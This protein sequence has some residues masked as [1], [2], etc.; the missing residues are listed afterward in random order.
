MARLQRSAG[1]VPLS[2]RSWSSHL[3]QGRPGHCLQLVSGR[4]PSDH[5]VLIWEPCTE[6]VQSEQWWWWCTNMT[7]K[8][9]L[10]SLKL[11]CVYMY[12]SDTSRLQ[13]SDGPSVS[14][15]KV[16][17]HTWTAA[18]SR[19]A[20]AVWLMAVAQH[21]FHLDCKHNKIKVSCMCDSVMLTVKH[22]KIQRCW[23]HYEYHYESHNWC[24]IR[25]AHFKMN[26][27]FRVIQG[28]PYWC[29][30]KSRTDCCHN[31]NRC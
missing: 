10:L 7:L 3:L 28:H 31:A 30:Q 19:L 22:T 12:A 24:A 2:L 6:M 16:R 15:V 4:G 8:F 18:T 20:N 13:S 26:R 23:L 14:G 11:T 25:K 21:Q 5:R 9:V 27:A 1:G 29:L 17:V